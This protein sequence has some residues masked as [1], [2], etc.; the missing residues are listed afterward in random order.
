MLSEVEP[1]AG[2]LIYQPEPEEEVVVP[3]ELL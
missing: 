3:E 2:A 1:E